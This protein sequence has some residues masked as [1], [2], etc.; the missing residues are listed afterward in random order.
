MRYVDIDYDAVVH[1]TDEAVLLDI[2]GEKVWLPLSTIRDVDS[3][4]ELDP[5]GDAIEIAE[6]IAIDKGLC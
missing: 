1:S 6:W 3:A 2:G 4:D 5:E